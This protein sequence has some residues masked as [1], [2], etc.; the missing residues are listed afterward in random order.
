MKEP[1]LSFLSEQ[2]YLRSFLNLTKLQCFYNIDNNPNVIIYSLLAS[3]IL[4][5]HPEVTYLLLL[6]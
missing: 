3:F 2:R 1:T 4:K 5:V 6:T